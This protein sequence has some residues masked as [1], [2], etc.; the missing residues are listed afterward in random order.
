MRVTDSV[1][2]AWEKFKRDTSRHIPG[3]LMRADQDAQY[4]VLVN[5]NSYLSNVLSLSRTR[6]ISDLSS[7]LPT[8]RDESIERVE[9]FTHRYS[10]LAELE[11]RIQ[12][13]EE[14]QLTEIPE[15]HL[16]YEKFADTILNSFET[17]GT[18]YE[19]DPEQT[20]VFRSMTIL[21]Q[22]NVPKLWLRWL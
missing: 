3:L 15:A 5:S 17:V 16:R 12:R 9:Q 21:L 18:A 2:V 4:L 22:V 6:K 10:Q 19:S 20:S 7:R 13:K 11:S 1:N 8:S 14:P